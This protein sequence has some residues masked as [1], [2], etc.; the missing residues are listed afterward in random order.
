MGDLWKAYTASPDYTHGLRARSQSLYLEAWNLWCKIVPSN[1][2]AD[3]ITT[4]RIRE[5]VEIFRDLKG[6]RTDR[7]AVSTIRSTIHVIKRLLNWGVEEEILKV[8]HALSHRFPKRRVGRGSPAEYNRSEYT[9]ILDAL[10]GADLPLGETTARAVIVLLG[11]QGVRAN[12][13]LHLRWEDV[14]WDDNRLVWRAE[15]DKMGNEWEQPIRTVTRTMLSGRRAF[16][17]HPTEG[18]VFPGRDRKGGASSAKPYSASSLWLALQRAETKAEVKH[19]PGRAM[20]GLRRRL[21]GDVARVS[22]SP[23][24]G[25]HAIGDMHGGLKDLYLKKRMEEVED[26]F[27]ALDAAEDASA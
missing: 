26:A 22:G 23:D 6:E 3:E 12:A 8:N 15:Y 24:L 18:W 5:T 7:Y 21:A 4:R 14:R 10:P 13:A 20:H 25:M 9:R 27:L 19:R 2:P 11:Q 16:L 17:G 1:T